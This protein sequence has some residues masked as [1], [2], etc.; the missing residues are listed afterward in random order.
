MQFLQSER[1]RYLNLLY[2][3]YAKLANTTR[4]GMQK[5]N[6]RLAELLHVKM[7]IDSAILHQNLQ[8]NRQ[9]IMNHKKKLASTEIKETT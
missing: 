5:F 8:I 1:E 3:E 7:E 2:I 6:S 9:R 4:E